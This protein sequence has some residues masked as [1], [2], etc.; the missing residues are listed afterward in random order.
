MTDQ[1]R[2][3]VLDI[4]DTVADTSLW[5]GVLDKFSESVDARGCIVFELQSYGTSREIKA[6]QYSEKY[7]PAVLSGYI[8]AFSQEELADQD[9]FEA[10]SLASDT[11]DLIG[12]HELALSRPDFFERP[13]VQM[14]QSVGIAH[15]AAGLLD[16]DDRRRSRFSVQFT[17]DQ[18]PLSP[19]RRAEMGQYL[20]HIAKALNLS[21]PA[22]RLA[23]TNQSLIAAM[24]KLRIGVCILDAKGR[25]A[26]SNTEFQ[27]QQQDYHAFYVDPTDRL[28]LQATHGA[29]R[30]E[31]LSEDALNH[32]RFG[33]RPRK[34]AITINRDGS[35]GVLCVDLAPL[36]HSDE[37]GSAAFRG[38]VLYSLDTSQPVRFNPQVM[39]QAFSLTAA[40][41][42]LVELL[43][44]GLTNGQIAERRDRSLETIKAQMKSLLAKT[45]CANRTQLVRM[46]SNFN[47]DY[48][49][50]ADEP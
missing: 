10:M 48:L 12:D 34:E 1:V 26:A 14:L 44:E 35:P 6:S 23:E 11:I 38:L 19:A 5:P 27:R 45:H 40:E 47:A 50:P 31:L 39:Q 20:P 16:K 28:H 8:E 22:N 43:N 17:E 37:I 7:D 29:K 30:F 32:G 49:L 25:I 18:G 42:A 9:Q 15:R 41:I 3:L 33:A 24:D 13:N 4:Y 36:D 2:D 21:G 46:L